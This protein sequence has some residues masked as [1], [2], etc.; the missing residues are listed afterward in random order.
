MSKNT[1]LVYSTD[2]KENRTCP[3]CKELAP[4]CRCIP[5]DNIIN[6]QFTA[7]FRL[8]KNGRGGK[9]VT[10][11]DGLPRHETYLKDL[12]KEIKTRCGTGGT[13]QVG[14]KSGILEI[15]GD[16]RDAIKKILTSKSIKFKGV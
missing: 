16:K 10:V 1:R 2:P 3:K 6:S 13:F 9:T 4:E 11:L 12:L 8:E 15:Q 5:E 7:I 14:P